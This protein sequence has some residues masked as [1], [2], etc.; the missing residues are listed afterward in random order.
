MSHL[1]PTAGWEGGLPQQRADLY[2]T[3]AGAFRLVEDKRLLTSQEVHEY[4]TLSPNRSSSYQ[5]TTDH[6]NS[7]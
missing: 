5:H 6:G 7:D 2:P 1:L 4:L 3:C